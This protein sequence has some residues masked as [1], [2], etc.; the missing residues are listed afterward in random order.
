MPQAVKMFRRTFGDCSQFLAQF[1]YT[2]REGSL[3]GLVHQSECM[4]G[5]DQ[6]SILLRPGGYQRVSGQHLFFGPKIVGPLLWQFFPTGEMSSAT[7]L[8]S[9]PAAGRVGFKDM[10]RS[11]IGFLPMT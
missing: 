1:L 3:L 4:H 8:G 11:E 2:A 10:A 6:G 9:R 7:R 5:H